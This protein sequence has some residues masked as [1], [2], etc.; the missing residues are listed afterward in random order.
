MTYLSLTPNHNCYLCKGSC[1]YITNVIIQI[2]NIFYLNKYSQLRWKFKLHELLFFSFFLF[3]FGVGMRG[4]CFNNFKRTTK[5]LLP[6][7]QQ[8]RLMNNKS[9]FFLETFLDSAVQTMLGN[10]GQYCLVEQ[11][12]LFHWNPLHISNHTYCHLL[13]GLCSPHEG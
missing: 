13:S 2:Q 8:R 4:M 11:L 1:L 5:A 6:W 3:F 10:I 9:Y 12:T 7:I